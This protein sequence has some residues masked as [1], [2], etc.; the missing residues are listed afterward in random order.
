MQNTNTKPTAWY[1]QFWPWFL[2]VPLIVTVI[3]GMTMLTFS[4]Q[5]FDGTVNDN[6]YKEGLAI[7]QTLERDHKAAELKMAA[8]VKIDNLTGDVLLELDGQ[9]ESW[10][11][12]LKLDFINP[13]R[14]AKD[15]SITLTQVTGNHY[16]GQVEKAPLNLWYMDI[17]APDGNWRL[18]GSAEFPVEEGFSLRAGQ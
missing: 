12:Q 8:E 6:Y 4:I 5:V 18:K 11:A 14:A 1:K 2:L 13:T 7:N 10:P 17:T 15:Y 16:R 3:V 9:L